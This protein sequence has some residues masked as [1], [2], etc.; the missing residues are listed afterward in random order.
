MKTSLIYDFETL[1]QDPLTGVAVSLA[2]TLFD[3]DRLSSDEPYTYQELLD[4][5]K[6]VKLS[7]A[8]QV[9]NYGRIVQASTL[10]WWKEQSPD[11]LKALAPSD[12]DL[13]LVEF[14]EKMEK[15]LWSRGY[16]VVLTRGN[17]FDPV[18]MTTLFKAV[19]KPEP[20]QAW[21]TIRDTR[22]LIEG[23]SFGSGLSNKYIPDDLEDQFVA[24]DPKHDVA[25]DLMRIQT[26]AQA[27]K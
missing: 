12:S 10:E 1:S 24:H 13:T 20:L 27:L 21:W 4:R 8:D 18:Y 25:M 16:D 15:E 14:V 19:G 26:L 5:T 9:E 11:A 2:Y 17:T 7:V 22:S 6:T 3:Y 23:M